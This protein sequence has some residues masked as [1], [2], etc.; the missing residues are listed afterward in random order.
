MN[1]RE[2]RQF[3]EEGDN[4]GRE[5]I[6]RKQLRVQEYDNSGITT[7]I[8]GK[9]RRF[10]ENDGDSGKTTATPGKRQ[11]KEKDTFRY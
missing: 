11:F 10:R 5:A 6:L 1:N 3:R 2:E 9:R 8:P 4:S 7:K